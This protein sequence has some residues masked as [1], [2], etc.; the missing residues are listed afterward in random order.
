MAEYGYG[1]R[2]QFDRP[3]PLAYRGVS[4]PE[5]TKPGAKVSIASATVANRLSTQPMKDSTISFS[6]QLEANTGSD[7][8]KTIDPSVDVSELIQFYHQ[9]SDWW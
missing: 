5:F 4:I 3:T 9:D 8:S 1:Y 6:I 7:T 2:T